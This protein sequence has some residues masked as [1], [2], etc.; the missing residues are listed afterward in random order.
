MQITKPTLP[1]MFYIHGGGWMT[2]SGS[3]HLQGPEY[4][5]DKNIVLVSVT[6]RLGVLGK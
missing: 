4:F 6:Y 2:G 1:V 3:L 5:M